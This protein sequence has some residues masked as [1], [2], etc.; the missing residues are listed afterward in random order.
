MTALGM[1]CLAVAIYAASL[2]PFLALVDA[3]LPQL[4]L[5]RTVRAL[6]LTLAALLMLLGGPD[7]R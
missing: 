6:P 2:V 4:R 1:T 3:D 5:P 7:A